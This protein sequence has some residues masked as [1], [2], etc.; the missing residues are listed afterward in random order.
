MPN[1]FDEFAGSV[2]LRPPAMVNNGRTPS[3]RRVCAEPDR[4]Q[5]KISIFT[6]HEK[7]RIETIKLVPKCAFDEQ[8][9]AGNNLN[10]FTAIFRRNNHALRVKE[11]T[12]SK[13]GIY[14]A[15]LKEQTENSLPTPT[16]ARVQ[17]AVIE[18]RSSAPDAR[19]GVL[20]SEA[21]QG[22]HATL[23]HLCIGIQQ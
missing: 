18:K 2:E 10:L 11:D 1:Q 16:R 22:V 9:A 13:Q 8:E 21:Q 15:C 12:E 5:A 14:T 23:K 17:R 20:S 3:N 4:S 19:M 7:I 6:V